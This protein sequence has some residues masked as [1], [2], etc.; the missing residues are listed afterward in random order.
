MYDPNSLKK[1]IQ[2]KKQLDFKPQ[3]LTNNNLQKLEF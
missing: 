1:F 3:M 2:K